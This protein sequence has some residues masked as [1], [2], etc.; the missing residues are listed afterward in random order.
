MDFNQLFEYLNSKGTE[1]EKSLNPCLHCWAFIWECACIRRKK[2]C[3]LCTATIF[4][5]I[6][7]TFADRISA[8]RSHN[9]SFVCHVN[10]L[11]FLNALLC[12]NRSPDIT[13]V[14]NISGA[15]LV[16]GLGT[17]LL[18]LSSFG[19]RRPI[20]PRKSTGTRIKKKERKTR[21]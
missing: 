12:A 3:S 18:L 16:A 10:I 7:S 20:P 17:L 1:K 15:D 6:G 9:S 4:A 13:F 14:E 19:A 5:L 21:A 8:A 2:Y 11:L